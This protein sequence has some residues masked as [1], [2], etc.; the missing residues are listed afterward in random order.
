MFKARL[1]FF[2][3][4]LLFLSSIS[5]NA[6]TLTVASDYWCP[7]ICDNV[8]HPGILVEVINEIALRNHLLLEIQIMPL[9]RALKMAKQ[10]DVDIVLA[11]TKQHITEFHLQQSHQVFGGWYNDFYALQDKATR[12]MNESQ[13]DMLSAIFRD[14]NRIGLIKGYEYGNVLNK[15]FAEY[16]N[17]LYHSTGNAPLTRNIKLLQ[18]GRIDFLLD[19]RF[20][21]DYQLARSNIHDIVRVTTE[22]S[23]TPLYLGFNPH[24]SHDVINLFDNGIIHLQIAGKLNHILKKY[25]TE[26]W[27]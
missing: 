26:T 10:G 2:F 25:N 5:L 9:S 22:G 11:L 24:I 17:N 16:P 15:L 1:H 23:L 20:N 8:R 7:F 14:N 19:S 13:T 12:L 21:L 18:K 6:K 4:T 27:Y 3:Y